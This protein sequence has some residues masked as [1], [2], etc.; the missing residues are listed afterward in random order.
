[1]TIIFDAKE[2]ELQEMTRLRSLIVNEHIFDNLYEEDAEEE[3]NEDYFENHVGI[4]RR[5]L[6]TEHFLRLKDVY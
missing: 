4:F 1:L 3:H 2:V 5:E 6:E